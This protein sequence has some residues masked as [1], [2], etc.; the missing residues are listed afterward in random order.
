[1]LKTTAMS[2]HEHNTKK[3]TFQDSLD[4]THFWH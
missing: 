1:M 4:K 3:G 2:S